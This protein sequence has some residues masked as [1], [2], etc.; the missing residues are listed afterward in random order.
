[1]ESIAVGTDRVEIN[2]DRVVIHALHPFCDW[3]IR[4][5]CRQPI[6]FEGRKFYLAAKS[7]G[8]A[9]FAIRYELAPWPPGLIEESPACFQYDAQAVA[10]RNAELAVERGRSVLWCF[11][12]PLYPVL[13]LCWSGFKERVLWPIGFEPGSITSASIMLVL[14]TAI[15]DT[16]ILG[17]FG[18]GIVILAPGVYRVDFWGW[19]AELIL[20]G[21][22]LLDCV[23]RYSQRLKGDATVPWGFLEWLVPARW[24]HQ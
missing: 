6:Y 11:L 18:G 24:R 20:I 22:L 14:G 2:A 7:V 10:E 8:T 13:G 4:E 5:F 21:I 3:R 1:M 9:G 23:A 12:L 15:V 17:V 16:S 19:L